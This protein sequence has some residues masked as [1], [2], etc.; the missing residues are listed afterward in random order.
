[1]KK[2]NKILCIVILLGLALLT[3]LYSQT[4]NTAEQGEIQQISEEQNNTQI[5]QLTISETK[6]EAREKQTN[7]GFERVPV[8]TVYGPLGIVFKTLEITLKRL[9]I[10]FEY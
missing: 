2:L 4:E 6:N 9:Y 1:M 3:R 10:L 5:S 7:E 8:N